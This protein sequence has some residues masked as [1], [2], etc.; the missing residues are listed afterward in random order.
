MVANL[1]SSPHR[2]ETGGLIFPAFPIRAAT[3]HRTGREP[4]NGDAGLLLGGALGAL[5]QHVPRAARVEGDH[6]V[7]TGLAAGLMFCLARER[8]V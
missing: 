4:S 3:M 2:V 6:A 1:A 8:E 7:G 5:Q